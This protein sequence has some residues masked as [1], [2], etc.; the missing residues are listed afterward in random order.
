MRNQV[1][2][3]FDG[4]VPIF[5]DVEL[6]LGTFEQ[7]QNIWNASM[8]VTLTTLEAVERAIAFFLSSDC[9]SPLSDFDVLKVN[10]QR[11]HV[12]S[13]R[14]QVHCSVGETTSQTCSKV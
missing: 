5:S 4:L 14:E 8:D 6:F 1:L 2:E 7:D 13:E 3:G 10:M 12:K 9:K 11:Q